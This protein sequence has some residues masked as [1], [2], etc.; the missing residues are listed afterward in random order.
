MSLFV[1]PDAR[2]IPFRGVRPVLSDRVFVA[3]GVTLVGDVIVAEGS[4]IWYGTVVRGDVHFIRIGRET[5]VQDNCV[6]HVT[7][8]TNSVTIGDHVTI[9]HG[10]VVHGATWVKKFLPMASAGADGPPEQHRHSGHAQWVLRPGRAA[11]L[12]GP[13]Y[14]PDAW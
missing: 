1:S 6:I 14:R 4:S 13:A 10:A 8:D 12:V 2:V 7:A 11:S 9:G 3:P 5:N